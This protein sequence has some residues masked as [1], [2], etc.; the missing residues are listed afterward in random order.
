M[1]LQ[2]IKG[3]VPLE[4]WLSDEQMQ[5]IA[6]E[7]NYSET[8]FFIPYEDHFI[9]AGLHQLTKLIFAGMLL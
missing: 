8:A 9:F 4:E 3:N 2:T 1:R 5:N 6:I 7:N